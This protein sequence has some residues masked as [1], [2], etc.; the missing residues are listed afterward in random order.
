MAM[1]SMSYGGKNVY[2][3]GKTSGDLIRGG[4]MGANRGYVLTRK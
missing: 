4:A 1:L 3:A 2:S